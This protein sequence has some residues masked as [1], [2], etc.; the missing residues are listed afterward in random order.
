MG[1]YSLGPMPLGVTEG[2]AAGGTPPTAVT[3]YPSNTSPA[4]GINLCDMESQIATGWGT[5]FGVADIVTGLGNAGI[6]YNGDGLNTYGV[7]PGNIFTA[8]FVV[9]LSNINGSSR[10]A[11]EV[12][13]ATYLTD[14]NIGYGGGPYND[15]LTFGGYANGGVGATSWLWGVTIVSQS[16]SNGSSAYVTGTASTAQDS[17][18]ATAGVFGVG[19]YVGIQPGR[20]GYVNP[21]DS[22]TIDVDV[23]ATNAGGSTNAA[24]RLSVDFV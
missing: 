7:P 13:T 6:G 20:S 8:T 14:W 12:D 23:T 2:V 10:T 21:G 1:T 4:A 24:F 3:I 16:L 18:Y 9:G 22:L 19:Q 11:I 17:T 15:I 5:I